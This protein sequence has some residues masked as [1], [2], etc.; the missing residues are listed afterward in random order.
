MSKIVIE[1]DTNKSTAIVKIGKLK[2]EDFDAIF[3]NKDILNNYNYTFKMFTNEGIATVKEGAVK[4]D[5]HQKL[6]LAKLTSYFESEN[7]NE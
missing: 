4:V 1:F 7:K 6:W 3:I 2:I 5:S